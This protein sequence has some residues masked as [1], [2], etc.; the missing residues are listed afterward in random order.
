M[1]ILEGSRSSTERAIPRGVA[2]GMWRLFDAS[3]GTTLHDLGVLVVWGHCWCVIRE[4]GVQILVEFRGA[5]WGEVGK[6]GRK[7]DP[8]GLMM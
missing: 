5:K 7:I 6:L 3:L 4:F 2:L 1:L 8:M